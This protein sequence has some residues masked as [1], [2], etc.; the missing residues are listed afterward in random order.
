MTF[1]WRH[2]LFGILAAA[3]IGYGV[4]RASLPY[5]AEPSSPPRPEQRGLRTLLK[6]Y[7]QQ[8]GQEVIVEAAA[9]AE[10][11]YVVIHEDVRGVAGE[12]VGVSRLL[13]V[14]E[15]RNV[16]VRPFAPLRAGTYRAALR[17]DDGDEAYQQAR[18]RQARDTEGRPAETVFKLRE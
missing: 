2:L 16:R 3:A 14:G 17:F 18:D 10:P 5:L 15:T 9:L 12:I 6:V 1:G 4:W 13:P 8:L 7:D 11:G